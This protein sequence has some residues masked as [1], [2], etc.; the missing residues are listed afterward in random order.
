MN[1]CQI[2]TL[3]I[4]YKSALMV[5]PARETS[6]CKLLIVNYKYDASNMHK[7]VYRWHIYASNTRIF[8]IR[9]YNNIQE[10]YKQ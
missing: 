5:A 9:K 3:T 1:I 2:H 8:E 6:G 4:A 10:I 7:Y